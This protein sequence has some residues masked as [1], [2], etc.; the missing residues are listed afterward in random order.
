MG[1]YYD[2]ILRPERVRLPPQSDLHLSPR[3]VDQLEII[4]PVQGK[5]VDPL[6]DAPFVDTVWESDDTVYFSLVYR[7]GLHV[8]PPC[9]FD[10]LPGV[11]CA[12][13]FPGKQCR[14]FC[15]TTVRVLGTAM[16]QT[17]ISDQD[18]RVI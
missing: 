1:Q 14:I 2:Q 12:G 11:W 13:T 15:Q 7:C 16:A 3:A 18:P 8:V 9:G 10:R 17:H 4:V 6:G 5:R